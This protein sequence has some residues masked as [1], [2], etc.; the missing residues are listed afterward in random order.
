MQHRLRKLIDNDELPDLPRNRQDGTR[1]PDFVIKRIMSEVL[2]GMKF[3]KDKNVV[4]GGISIDN[5]HYDANHSIKIG[6]FKHA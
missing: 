6:G 4:H 1:L 3:L 5:I 2:K